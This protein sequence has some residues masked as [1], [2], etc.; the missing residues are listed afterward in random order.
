MIMRMRTDEGS[1]RRVEGEEIP[2]LK[3]VLSAIERN[4]PGL[5]IGRRIV[6]IGL[7]LACH[8]LFRASEI[9]VEKR[10]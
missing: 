10:G 2:N 4:T 1:Q 7:A 6:W 8:L 3:D 5:G 9:F